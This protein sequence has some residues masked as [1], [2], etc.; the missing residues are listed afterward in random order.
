MFRIG[1][2][3]LHSIFYKVVIPADFM[4]KDLISL[5]IAY[6]ILFNV[7]IN[8]SV[9]NDSLGEK[10]TEEKIMTAEPRRKEIEPSRMLGKWFIV[11]HLQ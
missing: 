9:I 8:I 5:T 3:F 6:H 2:Q 7:F 10:E 1:H 11:I 4:H